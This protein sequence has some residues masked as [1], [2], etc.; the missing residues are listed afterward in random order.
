MRGTWLEGRERE[1]TVLRWQYAP[2]TWADILKRHGFTDIEAY[3]LKAPE[4]G[5]LGTLMV[6]AH[7]PR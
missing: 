7:A 4:P 5:D 3:V 2:E 6:R 1:L